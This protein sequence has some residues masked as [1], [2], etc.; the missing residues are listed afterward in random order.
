[1]SPDSRLTIFLNFDIEL[2]WKSYFITVSITYLHCNERIS[3]YTYTSSLVY[4]SSSIDILKGNIYTW[5]YLTSLIPA[6]L[7]LPNFRAAQL[8]SLEA[9]GKQL[10]CTY[11][12]NKWTQDMSNC[13]LL[14]PHFDILV[15][16]LSNF[17]F[18]SSGI[19]LR[20]LEKAIKKKAKE[21][22][23]AEDW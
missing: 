3:I 17:C 20:A 19:D 15:I 5:K 8:S 13:P 4:Q 9:Q 11:G 10:T 14:T 18:L 2:N 12:G 23:D 21:A 16:V 22:A 7:T 6:S 1:M